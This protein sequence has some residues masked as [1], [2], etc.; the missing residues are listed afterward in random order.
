[1]FQY[2]ARNC[3][4]KGRNNL[5]TVSGKKQLANNVVCQVC[6]QHSIKQVR[7]E[8]NQYVLPVVNQILIVVKVQYELWLANNLV[9]LPLGE[10]SCQ[11]DCEIGLVKPHC[12]VGIWL[13]SKLVQYYSIL[14]PFQK[15]YHPYGVF[16]FL[17][18]SFSICVY[19][20][21]V[22]IKNGLEHFWI[23]CLQLEVSDVRSICPY[24]IAYVVFL[25]NGFGI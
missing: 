17:N 25:D 2:V 10:L 18:I 21:I 22:W 16:P 24:R 19:G 13:Y 1:M 8:L 7:L 15:C 12:Q 3:D 6:P 9:F 20:K 4:W 23:R 14:V 5:L 11:R